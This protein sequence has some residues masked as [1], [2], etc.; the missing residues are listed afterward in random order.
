MREGLNNDN[1]VIGLCIKFAT[2]LCLVSWLH[3]LSLAGN[4]SNGPFRNK[5]FSSLRMA[6][7]SYFRPLFWIS[8]FW[9]SLNRFCD[10][11]KLV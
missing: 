5:S 8:E 6:V 3:T 9:I 11:T 10:N 4:D 2:I 1:R 7:S